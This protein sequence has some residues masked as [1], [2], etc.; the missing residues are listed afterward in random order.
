MEAINF[1]YWLKG[2]LS[3]STT[4]I[5]SETLAN[6]IIKKLNAVSG[7]EIK[8]EASAESLLNKELSDTNYKF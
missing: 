4:G 3:R 1:V 6:D 5:P 2:Y 8:N 7:V